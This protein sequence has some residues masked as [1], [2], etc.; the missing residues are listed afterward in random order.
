MSFH[1]QQA[2]GYSLFSN[3][4]GVRKI[5]THRIHH[6]NNA[7]N[8]RRLIK[9]GLIISLLVVAFFCDYYKSDF[10]QTPIFWI[11]TIIEVGCTTFSGGY[12]GW[13]ITARFQTKKKGQGKNES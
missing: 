6:Q 10:H 12:V 2:T 4:G 5:R 7:G 9:V 1:F 11:L 13:Q 3:F 8:G